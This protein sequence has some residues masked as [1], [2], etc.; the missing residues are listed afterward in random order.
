MKKYQDVLHL[1]S[2][3]IVLLIIGFLTAACG[4]GGGSETLGVSEAHA[5]GAEAIYVGNCM[6]Q[7]VY[8]WSVMGDHTLD[9][10]IWSDP[11]IH[12]EARVKL[13][14]SDR[15]LWCRKIGIYAV[16]LFP[17]P[18]DNH[19]WSTDTK[20]YDNLPEY[21]DVIL[22]YNASERYTNYGIRT[23]LEWK[24]DKHPKMEE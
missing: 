3:L 4:G 7:A 1:S 18:W 11:G 17:T 12:A 5:D 10:E 16:G 22:W 2:L 8:C 19:Q 24:E 15:W 13:H 23:P 6:D 20:V 21:I 14:G 9:I